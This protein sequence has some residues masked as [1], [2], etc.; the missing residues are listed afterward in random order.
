M[1][2]ELIPPIEKGHGRCGKYN[3]YRETV[4][5]VW[6]PYFK[7]FTVY[8]NK[9]QWDDKSVPVST[10]FCTYD[11]STTEVESTLL[12]SPQL[13]QTL[14]VLCKNIRDHVWE[15]SGHT[16]QISIMKLYAQR[17]DSQSKCKLLFCTKLKVRRMTSQHPIKGI[18]EQSRSSMKKQTTSKRIVYEPVF[19]AWEEISEEKKKEMVE[20]LKIGNKMIRGAAKVL[21][22]K[23]DSKRAGEI[24]S[25]VEIDTEVVKNAKDKSSKT[26]CTMCLSK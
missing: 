17:T 13:I 3:L 12:N 20:S 16:T 25:K 1:M 24:K 11:G 6:T 22:S 19:K 2:Q 23:K 14:E 21:P 26:Y 18:F 15:V 8:R 10:R 5:I 9:H 7:T 4:K